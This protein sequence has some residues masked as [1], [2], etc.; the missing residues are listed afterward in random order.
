MKIIMVRHGQSIAN[1]KGISQGNKDE[2]IDKPL[3]KKGKEQAEK[4]AQ[5]LKNEDIGIIYS[6]DLKRAKE[7][8]EIINEFH[9]VKIKSDNRLRDML[10]DENL[11]E[12]IKKCVNSF[13][14]IEKEHKNVLVVSH[15]SSVL[16][17]LAASTGNRKEGGKIVRKHSSTYG[18]TCISIV[19]RKNGKYK[20][21]L[22]GCR[23]HLE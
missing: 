2:W 11:E 16:T 7:T 4:V 10:N 5:R 18:N 15:G 17:L 1:S 6:S 12:F 21:K 23:K 3:S 22:I 14:D 19:E 9:N 13:R 8:A 20:I